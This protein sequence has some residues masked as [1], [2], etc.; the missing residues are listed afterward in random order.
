MTTVSCL[1]MSVALST[2]MPGTMRNWTN[3]CDSGAAA[4][5]VRQLVCFVVRYAT[6]EP[7][8]R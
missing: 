4:T 8:S 5:G 7:Y 1:A 2:R 6:T 3:L